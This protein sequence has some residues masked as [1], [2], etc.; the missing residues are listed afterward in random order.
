MKREPCLQSERKAPRA[1]VNGNDLMNTLDLPPGPRIGALL[2]RLREAE[3]VGEISDRDDALV[4]A[5]RLLA[6]YELE[7]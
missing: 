1:L 7:V 4:L 2:E 6:N 5:A 3:A